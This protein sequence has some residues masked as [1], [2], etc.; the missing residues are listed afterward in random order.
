MK[1]LIL[2][3]DQTR[4]KEFNRRLIGN[5]VKNVFTVSETI[6]ALKN[7]SWDYIFLDHDLGGKTFVNSGGSEETGWDVAVWLSENPDRQPKTIIIHSF[8]PCGA[9]NMKSLLP[10]AEIIPGAWTKI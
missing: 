9:K 4:H 3:D 10:N 1:I 8:N 5:T 6:E 7:E 2:D